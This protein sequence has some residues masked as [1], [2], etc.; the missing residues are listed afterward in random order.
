MRPRRFPDDEANRCVPAGRRPARRPGA[1]RRDDAP[2]D[3]PPAP[4]TKA[5]GTTTKAPDGGK[6]AP[7]T[8]PKSVATARKAAT[9]RRGHKRH[10]IV[11]K[12]KAAPAPATKS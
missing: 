8:E 2:G 4:V 7:K 12:P 10:A 5:A 6:V 11:T 9:R 3:G 1:R